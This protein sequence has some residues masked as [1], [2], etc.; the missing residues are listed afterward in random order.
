MTE[1]NLMREIVDKLNDYN[2]RYYVLDDPTVSDSEYD[3]LYDQLLEIEKKTGVV[4][5][6]SPTKRVGDTILSGFASHNHIVRLYSLD[7]CRTAE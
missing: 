3:S 6:D 7:K 5:D 2:Y 1:I 4:F